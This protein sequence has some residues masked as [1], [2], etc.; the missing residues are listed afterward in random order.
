M[1]SLAQDSTSLLIEN[2]LQKICARISNLEQSIKILNPHF[3]DVKSQFL[4][5]MLPHIH[6]ISKTVVTGINLSSNTF[7]AAVQ[8]FE[9]IFASDRMRSGEIFEQMEYFIRFTD[10]L[11]PIAKSLEDVG[12]ELG[13][14]ILKYGE[15]KSLRNAFDEVLATTINEKIILSIRNKLNIHNT[16][17]PTWEITLKDIH[18][19]FKAIQ[20]ELGH[21]VVALQGFDL[22]RQILE[23]RIAE[24]EIFKHD[25]TPVKN[26]K[27]PWEELKRK[28][29]AQVIEKLVTDEEKHTYAFFFPESAIEQDQSKLTPGQSLFF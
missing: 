26:K 8:T 15:L 27:M 1:C 3:L 2:S 6:E 19:E 4:L 12:V 5:S 21:C 14:N 10:Q 7:E 28:I 23:H 25:L 22:V 16:P 13:D 9:A 24:I 29:L 20:T 11:T 18:T 17:N